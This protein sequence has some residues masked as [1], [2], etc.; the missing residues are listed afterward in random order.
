MCSTELESHYDEVDNVPLSVPIGVSVALLLLLLLL[1]LLVY[2]CFWRRRHHKALANI[3]QHGAL[4]SNDIIPGHLA[5]IMSVDR[6]IGIVSI[7]PNKE[8]TGVVGIDRVTY[9]GGQD[10]S[11]TLPDDSLVQAGGQRIK[12]KG[13]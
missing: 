1:V 11:S 5:V 4:N 12:R 6:R 2:A 3:T 7:L 13:N 9:I 8:P 10:D